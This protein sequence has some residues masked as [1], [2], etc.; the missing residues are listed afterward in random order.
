MYTLVSDQSLKVRSCT[1]MN[2][3]QQGPML[4]GLLLGLQREAFI[5]SL[6]YVVILFCRQKSLSSFSK[7][8]SQKV[9]FGLVE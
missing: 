7:A 9:T 5:R 6:S 3:F 2:S 4:G 8:K 1:D